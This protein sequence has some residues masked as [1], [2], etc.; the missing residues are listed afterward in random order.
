MSTP[1]NL[2]T[3]QLLSAQLLASADAQPLSKPPCAP[4]GLV[5]D[6]IPNLEEYLARFAGKE[7]IGLPQ[8][9][10]PTLDKNTLGLR[11][12]TLLAAPPN[13]G[14]TALALQI[15]LDVLINNPDACALIVSLEMSA[16]SL[17]TRLLSR[18]S[19][20][21]WTTLVQGDHSAGISE[22]TWST[23]DQTKK[24]E[25]YSILGK[26]GT[27]LCI[28]DRDN[29]TPTHIN[30]QHTTP[31]P[32]FTAEAVLGELEKLK[33]VSKCTRAFVLID[34]LQVW[35]MP[36]NS[37]HKTDIE[38]DQWRVGQMLKLRS[39]IDPQS[40][41][42][43]ALFV[44]SETNKTSWK[45][46]SE[47]NLS[48]VMGSARATYAP[49]CVMLLRP[50]SDEEIKK[51][52]SEDCGDV[53]KIKIDLSQQ[54]QNLAKLA[55]IK[56]RDGFTRCTIN[57]IFHFRQ[58]HFSEHCISLP[59]QQVKLQQAKQQ[60]KQTKIEVDYNEPC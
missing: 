20:L 29:M 40:L 37:T 50:F 32:N 30:Q 22:R 23:E 49:D 46:D 9:T 6:S 58:S 26:V 2:N 18:L 15:A 35:P 45:A 10:L 47:E 1:D 8:R 51:Y 27:R 5:V 25:A 11:G 12:L 57:L 7:F 42:S 19:G 17:M 31:Q 13:F 36:S 24:H 55:I 28:L 38:A 52:C 53:D 4:V 56:G 43:G 41:G 14:K 39:S 59:K 54:G 60:K 3:A 33:Q 44:I 16:L 34:Y 21:D 48:A